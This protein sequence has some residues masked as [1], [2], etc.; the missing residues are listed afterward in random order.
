[1]T[2]TSTLGAVPG[3]SKSVTKGFMFLLKPLSPGDH[4]IEWVLH[5][6]VFGDFG[7][8]WDLHVAA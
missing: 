5:H 2:G 8:V 3:L 6:D 7:A 4:R 1:V